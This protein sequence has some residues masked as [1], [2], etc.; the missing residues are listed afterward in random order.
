[1]QFPQPHVSREVYLTVTSFLNP[2]AIRIK[3]KL[4]P[5]MITIFHKQAQIRQFLVQYLP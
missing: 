2:G 1:M 3:A 5:S 4:F